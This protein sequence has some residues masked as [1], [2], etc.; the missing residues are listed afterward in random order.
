RVARPVLGDIRGRITARIEGDAAVTTREKAQ[1]RL[2]AA[3]VAGEF[4]HED[5][6]VAGAGLLVIEADAV[7][8]GHIGHRNSLRSDRVFILG[9]PAP[10]RQAAGSTGERAISRSP[11]SVYNRRDGGGG[12]RRNR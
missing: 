2:V 4:M 11:R 6:R 8:A 5:D 10:S 12:E 3:I 1:L 7:V 9:A